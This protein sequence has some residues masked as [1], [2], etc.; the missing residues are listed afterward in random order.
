M[1]LTESAQLVLSSG[2]VCAVMIIVLSLPIW[3]IARSAVA[4]AFKMKME[5]EKRKKGEN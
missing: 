4:D 1:Q 3:I 2:V 5:Q